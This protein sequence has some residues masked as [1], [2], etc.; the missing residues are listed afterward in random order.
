M[1]RRHFENM[2]IFRPDVEAESHTAVSANCFSLADAVSPHRRF[3]FRDLKNRAVASFR[4]DTLDY[5]D[6]SGEGGFPQRR[7][8]ASLP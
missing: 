6:H 3:R 5:V 1:F 8:K 7:E 2:A 4:F